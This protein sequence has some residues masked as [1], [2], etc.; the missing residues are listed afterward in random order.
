M[1]LSGISA[2]FVRTGRLLQ[3]VDDLGDRV[4]RLERRQN[5]IARH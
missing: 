4:E 5:G 1:A 2:V 3:K